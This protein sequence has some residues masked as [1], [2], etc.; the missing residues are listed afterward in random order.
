MYIFNRFL[1][2]FLFFIFLN[3]QATFTTNI[4]Y[5]IMENGTLKSTEILDQNYI[6]T[7]SKEN[8]EYGIFISANLKIFFQIKKRFRCFLSKYTAFYK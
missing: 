6:I 4:D 5:V 2:Y 7:Y 8:L 3:S 1:T